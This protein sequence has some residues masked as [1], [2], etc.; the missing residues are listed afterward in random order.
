[1]SIDNEFTILEVSKHNTKTDCWV[2][3]QNKVYDL[4]NFMKNHTGGNDPLQV[5]GGDATHLFFSIHPKRARDMLESEDFISKYYIGKVAIN[6]RSN[7]LSNQFDHNTKFYSELRT[8]VEKEL[9]VKGYSLRD[10]FLYKT[11]NICTIILFL[12]IYKKVFGQNKTKIGWII[13]LVMLEF[14]IGTGIGHEAHHGGIVKSKIYRWFAK[15]IAMISINGG[16]SMIWMVGHNV[17]HHGYT[18]TEDDKDKFYH[19]L[20]RL[21]KYSEK[22]YIHRYQHFYAWFGYALGLFMKKINLSLDIEEI[23]LNLDITGK[24]NHIFFKSIWYYMF[25]IRP[26]KKFGIM[27]IKDIILYQIISSLYQVT[28]FT[29]NHNQ[30]QNEY[31]NYT[32]NDFAIQQIITS[33]NYSSGNKLINYITG[34]LNHQIEHHLF[35]SLSHHTYP[36]IHKIV[37]KKCLKEG[38][39]Y[40]NCPSVFHAILEHYNFLKIMGQ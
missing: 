39:P 34:G 5:A 18:N 9:K 31:H 8:E 4:T 33:T 35:P 26:I 22:L 28:L 40:N 3:I 30:N 11:C 25:I 10:S 1:M 27:K 13:L 17:V 21:S 36:E 20:L 16:W 12:L 7:I 23:K 29:I 14:M 37:L 32:T 6:C 38:I 19:K 15:Y 24:L 2:I